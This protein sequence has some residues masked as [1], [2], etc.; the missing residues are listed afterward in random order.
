[1]LF[2]L[3]SKDII[4]VLGTNSC[5]LGFLPKL[6]VLQTLW[7]RRSH[8]KEWREEIRAVEKSCKF[9]QKKEKL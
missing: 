3:K 6:K 5:R 8:L 4:V 1:M 2:R 7:Q 9:K